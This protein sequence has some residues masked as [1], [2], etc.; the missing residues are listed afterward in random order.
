MSVRGRLYQIGVVVRDIEA[1]MTHYRELFGVGP[2]KCLDTD[3]TAWYRGQVERVANRN[4]FARWGDLYLEMVE[5]RQGGSTAR[6]WLESRGE[7]IFH[8]GYVTDD[9]AQRPVGSDVCFHPLQRVTG[10]GEPA[11]L[12]LD[13]LSQLG[14][15]IELASTKLANDLCCWIDG[16]QSEI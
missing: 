11:I 5:P 13:T 2:F 4:A 12:H 14:Y 8:L 10:Q 16:L 3:Y 7:G 1:G 9:L 15:F 6:E